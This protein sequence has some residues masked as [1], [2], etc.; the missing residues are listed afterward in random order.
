MSQLL[1]WSRQFTA[2]HALFLFDS[3][4]SGTVFK[5]RALP[6]QPPYIT[7]ATALP[8]RQ[9]ITAGSAGEEVP[10]RSEFTPAFVDALK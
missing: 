1:A 4:F 7:Q 8:V 6:P 3:C 2:K 9:F 10:A 5:T